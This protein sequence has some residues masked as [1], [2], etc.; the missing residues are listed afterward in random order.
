MKKMIPYML[1]LI[2]IFYGLPLFIKETILAMIA[3]L[4]LIPLITFIVSLLYGYKQTQWI[5]FPFVVGCLFLPTIFLFYNESALIYTFIYGG[6]SFVG[7][8]IGHLL[9]KN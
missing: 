6:I 1:I 2:L 9:K 5:I 3:L 8:L 7:A 4:C